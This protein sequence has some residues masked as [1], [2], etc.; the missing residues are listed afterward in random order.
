MKGTFI[1]SDFVKARDNSIRFLEVNTDTVVYADI[2][3]VEFNWQPVVDHVSGSYDILHIISKPELH[4]EAVENL[5]AK[6]ASQLPDLIVSESHSA[7]TDMY[8]DTV[9][10]ASNKFILRLAYDNNAI[11]D[12]NYTSDNFEAVKLMADANHQADTIPF[13]GVSGSVTYNTINSASYTDNVPDAV[14]KRKDAASTDVEFHRVA[15]WS[16]SLSALTSSCYIQSFEISDESLADNA[17]WSYRNYSVVYDSDL[18]T[19]DLGTTIK[20]AAFTLPTTSQVNMQALTSSLALPT[21]HYH[22]FSTS[23]VKAQVRKEG[24]FYTEVLTSASG[25][26]IELTDVAEGDIIKSFYIPGMPDSDQAEVYMNYV[27]TGS[28]WPAG[29]KL[30]GSVA[31]AA[32]V[33]HDSTEGILVGMTYSGSDETFYMGPSTSVLAYNSGSDNIKFRPVGGLIEDDI[34]LVDINGNVVDITSNKLII[35]DEGFGTFNSVDLEPTDNIVIG[36]QPVFFAYHNNKGVPPGK[37][38][39][40]GAEILMSDGTY[41]AIEDVK[42]GDSVTT[43]DGPCCLVEDTFI[44]N[45]KS[46]KKMYTKENLTVTD[47]HPLF[48]NGEWATADKLGWNSKYMFVDK[49]YNLKTENNFII[50]G[51]VASGTTHDYLNVSVDE[52]GYNSISGVKKA[53]INQI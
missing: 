16:A 7:L 27:I 29:S 44:Y 2:I 46:I 28:S 53:A 47:S 17:A 12:S 3:D 39:M 45:I 15:N 37:C 22:E 11:L 26:D 31:Q 48:V 41:K 42:V 35:T 8:P 24:V 33:S 4:Y 21:K 32:V 5:K 13:Y 49:L 6:V 14:V 1:S 30:T 20:Y 50:E 38:F 52:N 9:T 23:N 10:D 51:I 25:E 43:K 36:N 40:P 19:L 34:Y 18:K